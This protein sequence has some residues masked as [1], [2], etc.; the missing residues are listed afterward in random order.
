MQSRRAGRPTSAV[1]SSASNS[2]RYS[3]CRALKPYS[4][5]ISS[6]ERWVSSITS[7]V[8]ETVS[9]AT[10][11]SSSGTSTSWRCVRCGSLLRSYPK[12]CCASRS[13]FSSSRYATGAPSSAPLVRAAKTA[14]TSCQ[15]DGIL[16]SLDSISWRSYSFFALDLLQTFLVFLVQ[17]RN[18]LRNAYT[19]PRGFGAKKIPNAEPATIAT[20]Q[21]TTMTS[22]AVVPPAAMAAISV[23][24]ATHRGFEPGAEL[25]PKPFARSSLAACAVC[26]GQPGCPGCRLARLL[27]FSPLFLRYSGLFWAEAPA[28]AATFYAWLPA[29][30]RWPHG[31]EPLGGHPAF[32]RWRSRQ[33]YGFVRWPWRTSCPA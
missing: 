26:L 12:A 28:A 6:G 16:P 30:G 27:D 8:S 15:G 33:L 25:Q 22:R 4:S 32:V 17:F 31:A 18:G 21:R 7:T 1:V 10:F 14:R 5:R 19:V 2:V 23:C 3:F 9:V 24:V 11:P 13:K 20:M 29:N